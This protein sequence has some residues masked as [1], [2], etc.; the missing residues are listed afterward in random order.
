MEKKAVLI[1]ASLSL[2]L[3]FSICLFFT[4]IVPASAEIPN[5]TREQHYIRVVCDRKDTGAR[6]GLVDNAITVVSPPAGNTNTN[7]KTNTNTNGSLPTVGNKNTNGGG[8]GTGGNTNSGGGGTTTSKEISATSIL[9]HRDD[10]SNLGF[11]DII[12]ILKDIFGKLVLPLGEAI[13]VIM[14]ILGAYYYLTA[15]GNEEKAEKGKKTLFWSIVGI[16]VIFLAWII[17]LEL[18]KILAQT[19]P[20]SEIKPPYP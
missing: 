1:T 15:Y 13:A 5:T 4:Q 20:P 3:L 9:P 7:T 17:I 19:S 12:G 6:I 8:G 16:V 11:N 10:W 14:L 2:F 18:W